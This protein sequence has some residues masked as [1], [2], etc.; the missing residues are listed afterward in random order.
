MASDPITTYRENLRRLLRP[1][2]IVGIG[3]GVSMFCSLAV[4]AS[5]APLASAA[6]ASGVVSPDTSRKTIQHLEGGILRE[7]KIVEG[8]TV[9]KGQVL[10]T[11]EPILAKAQYLS[12]RQQW[13]RLQITRAR[14]EALWAGKDSFEPP[15]YPEFADDQTLQAFTQ[16]QVALFEARRNSFKER[17][18]IL[19][20]QLLQLDQQLQAKT[21]ENESLTKQR[22]FLEEEIL[23]KKEL[24]AKNLA[25]KPEWMALERAR[26]DN[27]G[28]G[29]S[30]LA[31]M[32]AIT[33]RKGE[34]S[35]SI[36]TNRTNFNQEISDQLVKTNTDISQLEETLPASEDVL[37]RTDILA[38]TDGIVLN[39]RF[40]TVGGVVRPGE[41]LVDIVPANED[42]YIDAKLSPNDIDVVR[43]GQP[44]EIY[45][46][47]DVSRNAPRLV[48]ELTRV[49]AD[50]VREQV[51]PGTT[52]A[53]AQ[54]AAGYFEI[55]VRIDKAELARTTS[56]VMTPGMP[57][58][59]YIL[60]GTRTFAQYFLDPIVKSFR[61]AFRED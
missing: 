23:D 43:V 42:L 29:Q 2:I 48:G 15:S 54:Q 13:M 30:N 18:E 41:A 25:R 27:I 50:L 26:A 57:A 51:Q 45:L 24:I 28:R 17:D 8:A 38:P 19:K 11:L 20:Q 22:E 5:R 49:G 34:V 1:T 46:T 7:I 10:F 52:Q 56:M 21:R 14:L 32:A 6:I 58:E 35:L 40:K 47:P 53:Q 4:W 39:V 37:K 16:T 33:E 59:V 61:R 55:R 36:V 9:R 60:T 3:V 12:K 31:T 44:A